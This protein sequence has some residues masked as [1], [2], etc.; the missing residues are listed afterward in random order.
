MSPSTKDG[1]N[2]RSRGVSSVLNVIKR[3][4]ISYPGSFVNPGPLLEFTIK[5]A[6]IPIL[7]STSDNIF[8]V[9]DIRLAFSKAGRFRRLCNLVGLPRNRLSN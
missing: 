2:F 4:L 7:K 1:G 9:G 3:N 8:R 6:M 5:A